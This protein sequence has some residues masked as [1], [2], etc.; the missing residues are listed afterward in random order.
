MK[1]RVIIN[2]SMVCHQCSAEEVVVEIPDGLDPNDV[3]AMNALAEE[4]FFEVDNYGW[5]VE[6]DAS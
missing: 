5:E 2:R 1:L 6:S 3:E 4:V